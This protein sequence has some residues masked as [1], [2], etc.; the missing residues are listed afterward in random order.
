MLTV[1]DEYTRECMAI[2]TAR[3]IGSDDA[4]HTLTG[5]FT[6]RG[7]PEHIRSN[8]GPEFTARAVR[9]WLALPPFFCDLH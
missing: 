7:V 8:N 6:L 3:R 4:M 5:L 1:I 9:D 2:R